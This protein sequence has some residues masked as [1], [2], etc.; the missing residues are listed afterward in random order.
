MSG[1]AEQALELLTIALS[2]EVPEFPAPQL[3]D[4]SSDIYQY[5]DFID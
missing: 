1:L 3:A 4:N 2:V 5:A